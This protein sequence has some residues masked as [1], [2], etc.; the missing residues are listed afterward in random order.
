MKNQGEFEPVSGTIT[1]EFSEHLKPTAILNNMSGSIIDNK[2]RIPEVLLK[3]GK[4]ITLN[5][6]AQG[7]KAG[8]GRA[9]LKFMADFLVNPVISQEST[10]IY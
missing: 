6:S 4:D 5:I 9:N 2:I 1:I 8:S 7:V 3:P 10:N